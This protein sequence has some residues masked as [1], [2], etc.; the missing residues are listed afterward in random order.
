MNQRAQRTNLETP[1]PVEM[2]ADQRRRLEDQENVSFRSLNVFQLVLEFPEQRA[3]AY[4]RRAGVKM[5]YELAVK[6]TS[7]RSSS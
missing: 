4:P 3:G 1:S 2:S 5:E 7:H 6:M